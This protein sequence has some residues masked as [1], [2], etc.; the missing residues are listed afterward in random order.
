MTFRANVNNLITV[1]V[2]KIIFRTDKWGKNAT[3]YFHG[4]ATTV[5][6]SD[7]DIHDPEEIQAFLHYVNNGSALMVESAQGYYG[8]DWQR[9]IKIRKD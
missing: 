4:K 7:E 5:F 2:E 8:T 3:V 1:P 9:F 6:I